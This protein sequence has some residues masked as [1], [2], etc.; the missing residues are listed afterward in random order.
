M[1]IIGGMAGKGSVSLSSTSF[2]V[3]AR[4]KSD[5]DIDSSVTPLGGFRRFLRE[6]KYLFPKV[7]VFMLLLVSSFSKKQLL[8]IGGSFPIFMIIMTMF[9]ENA[10]GD[11][12]AN[13]ESVESWMRYSRLL[14]LL[15]FVWVFYKYFAGYHAAEHMAIAAYER[16]GP[17]GLDRIAEQSRIHGH[18]GGRF[19]APAALVS[20]IALLL[21]PWIGKADVILSLIVFEAILWIDTFIGLERIAITAKASE[22]IQSYISTKPPTAEELRVGQEALRQLLLAHK[23]L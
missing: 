9:V 12:Q 13:V 16:H 17:T 20:T 22:W 15:P 14:I 8:V 1:Q 7:L 5:G 10:G 2:R 23:E 21:H 11:P 4:L 19:I 3:V 6:N 18:C